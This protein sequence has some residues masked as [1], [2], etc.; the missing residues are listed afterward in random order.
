MTAT[1]TT[2]APP[3][4]DTSSAQW[5]VAVGHPNWCDC[6]QPGISLMRWQPGDGVY[7]PSDYHTPP[8]TRRR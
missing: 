6:R 5:T 8:Y 4:V 1:H 3:M 7:R 2:P